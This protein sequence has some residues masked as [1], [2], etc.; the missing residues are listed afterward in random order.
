[1][2]QH[3]EKQRASAKAR[4]GRRLRQQNLAGDLVLG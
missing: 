4:N 1:M 2:R 3:R